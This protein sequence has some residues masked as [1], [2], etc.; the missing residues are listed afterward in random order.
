M[1]RRLVV[2][3]LMLIACNGNTPETTTTLVA[4]TAPLAI[5]GTVTLEEPRNPDNPTCQGSDGF[6]DLAER[7]N[8]V[9]RDGDGAVMGTGALSVGTPVTVSPDDQATHYCQFTFDVPLTG[10]AD[11]YTVE[12]AG[13]EGPVYSHEEME[14]LGWVV[15]LTIG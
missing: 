1:M 12:I 6:D 13:R 5:T 2:V 9:V 10:A 11:F 15:E 3:A 7:A 8:V 4:T 14:S